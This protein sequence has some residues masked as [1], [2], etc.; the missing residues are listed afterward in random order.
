MPDV[1]VTRRLLER[2]LIV[3]T[4][5]EVVVVVAQILVTAE[6]GTLEAL[7][8][9]VPEVHQSA[10]LTVEIEDFLAM[11]RLLALP[12]LLVAEETPPT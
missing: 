9:L 1:V 6:V 7:E 10:E 12:Q 5:V 8:A 4:L 2:G 3:G 11:G